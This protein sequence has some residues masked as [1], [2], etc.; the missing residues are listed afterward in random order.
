MRLKTILGLLVLTACVCLLFFFLMTPD[1]RLE[2]WQRRDDCTLCG[3]T[4]ASVKAKQAQAAS[5]TQVAKTERPKA[6]LANAVTGDVLAGFDAWSQRYLQATAGER[7][8]MIQEGQR[9]AHARRPIFKQLIQSDPRRALMEA[10]PMVVRQSLPAEIVSELEERVADR[11]ELRVYVAGPESK[12]NGDKAFLRYVET[13]TGRTY[14]TYVYG[15]REF[16]YRSK[17]E[18]HVIGV[19]MEGELALSESPLRRLEPG[20]I[21]PAGK[22]QVEVCPVSGKNTARAMP[23]PTPV[24][25]TVTAVETGDEVIFLCDGAH[26]RAYENGLIMGEAGT[27]G[28]QSFTGAMPSASVPSVG[29]VKV[30]Y[31]PAIFADQS[32]TPATE[33]VM[34]DGLRQAADFYQTQSY[35]RLTL[36]A[37]VT[38][39]VKLP[40]NQAW[41]NGKDTTSGFIKEVDGLGAEMAHAKEAARAAGY[42]WQDYH[43][44]CVRATGGARSPTSY[45]SIGIGQVWMRSDNA[46]TIAHEVG[47]AFG[48][49]H[50]NFWLTNGASV[51][52]PGGNEEYGDIYDNM[53]STSPPAGH[54]NTQAKNQI[55]WMPPEFAPPITASGLYRIH[56]FD[57]PRL[58][59]GKL[60]ALQVRKDAERTF[61][62]EYRTLFP[63]NTWV[64]N[65]L[66][67]G[68]KWSQN[69]GDNIQL[70]DTTP[71]SNNGKSDAPIAVGSTFSDIESGIHVT[72]VAVNPTTSPPS[73]DVQV[74][75]GSFPGNNVPTLTLS[76]S[77]PVVPTNTNVTFTA[78]AADLDGDTL[79]YSWR[80]HDG[81]ISPN[82]PTATR[83]FSSN[84]I[85]NVSCVVSDMKG[86][87]A[88]RNA[89][90]TVG[91]GGSRFTISGRVT[92]NGVGMVGVNVTTSG[93]NG[94]LTDSD[95]YYVIANLA[96][97]SY[98]ATPAGHGYVFNEEFN[99]SITVGPSFTGA[100]FT[101]EELPVVTLTAPTAVAVEGGA[102]GV[103]RLTR[104]GS[105]ALPLAVN[106]LVVRGTAAKTTDYTFAPDYT[107]IS[108]TPYFALT[109]PAD[110]STLDVVVAPVNDAS[111][112]GDEEVQLILGLD[113]AYV[114]GAQSSAAI[115]IQDNDTA[116][117][118]VSL[119]ASTAQ[120]VEGSGQPIT[121]T[122]RR[123]GSTG[124]DLI[125][126]YTIA[127]T[128]TAGNGVDYSTLSGTATI[129]Q[130]FASTTFSITPLD[131]SLAEATETV[132]LSIAS[133]ALFIADA[134][135]N[136]IS[137]RIVD[138]D[139][140]VV[141]LT[142]T[143]ATATEV[144]RTAPGA[145]PDPGTFLLTRSG[146]TSAALTVYYSVAGSALHGVDYEALPGSVTFP[147][148]ETQ[149][150]VTIMPRIEG[151][152]EGNELVILSI[153]DGNE[154]YRSGTSASGT[155]TISDQ[156]TDK[157]LLEVT[158][159]GGIAAEPS[160]NG[161]FR[162]TAKGGSGS[163]T[164]NYT[165]SGTATPGIDFTVLS[166]T[167]TLAL[168]GGTVT[169][170]ISVPVINDSDVEDMETVTLTLNDIPSS[171]YSL[172]D[173][174]KSAT[175]FI[176]DDEQP[177][178]FVDPQIGT[179]STHSISESTT[180]TTLKYYISRTG[181]TA[182][183]L[184]VN[185]TMTGT[186][187]SGVDFTSTNLT[188][189]ATIPIGAPGVDISFNTISDTTFEGTE[190]ATLSLS[191]GSYSRGP[192]AT[193][194]ITDDD[195]GAQTVNFASTGGSGSESNTT[196]SIPVSLSS[197]AVGT[198]TVD[199]LL[200]TGPRT[201]TMMAGTWV[202]VIRTGNSYSA[203]QSLD[204]V[205]FT[206]RG[207][208]QTI[209]GVPTT[210]YLAGIYVTSGS[211]GVLANIQM[212]SLSVTGLEVGGSAGA[213]ASSAIGTQNPAGGQTE[214]S[215]YYNIIAGGPDISQTST[216]D[217]GRIIY[218]PITSS[219]NC[220]V[221][222]RVLGMTGNSTAIKAGVTIRESTANNVRHM[223]CLAETSVGSHRA[224]YRLTSGGN[225]ASNQAQPTYTKPR[226]LRLQRS[227][228]DFTSSIS[229]D[230][231]AWTVVGPAQTLPLSTLCV[232]G[233]AASA[234]SDGLLT[235]ATFDNVTLSTGGALT[236][237]TIGYVNEPGSVTESGGTWTITASGSG[238]LHTTSST[239]DEGHMAGASVS[240]DFTL[241]ARLNN[242]SGGASNAQAGL[243]VRETSNYR[244]RALWYGMVA[245]A[246]AS[247][248]EYR[249]RLSAVSSGEGLSVDYALTPGTLTFA[250][251]EQT[252]NITLNVTND[253]LPEP[254]EFVT[255]MLRYPYRSLLGA[256]ST[257]TY[258]I[259]DDDVPTALLP[260]VGF[261]GAASSGLET[262]SP[263]QIAVTLSDPASTAV[264]IDYATNS[265]GTATGGGTDFTDISGTITFAPGETLK[266]ISLPVIDDSLVEA[267]ETVQLV[268]TAPTNAALS[269]T[270]T[271]TFTITDDDTP[272]VTLTATDAVANEA[273]DTGTFTFSRNGVTTSALTVN[274]TRSGTA[275]SG[276]DY[277]AIITPGTITFDIGEATKTVTV[278]PLQNTANEANETVILTL[279]AGSGYT[280]GSPSTATVTIEDDDV[281]TI[282]LTATD[283]IASEAP[284]NPGEF[285]LERTGPITSSVNVNISVSGTATNGTDYTS[286]ATTRTFGVG[287][288]SITIPVTVT[289][290]ST[291][292]GIEEVVISI[293][294]AA[295]YIVGTPSVANV[296]IIDDDLPPSVFISS[297]AS[298]STIINA[299]N[300]LQLQSTATD[301][302]L[303]SPLGYTWSQ[304]F[305]PG[306][307][308]FASPTASGSAASFSTPGIYGLRITVNDGQFTASDDLIVQ[309]G[310]FGYANWVGIDQGP[311]GV[312]GIS[313]E[314]AGGNYTLIGAG[315]GYTGTN[316]SGHMMFRQI[317]GGTGDATVTARL[318]SVS[319]P[320][321][322]LAGI[323][324]RDT[325]WKGAKRSNLVLTAGGSLQFRNRT[326][327]NVADTATTATGITFPCWMKLERVSGSV[328]ASYASDVAGTPGT[329]T[330]I[331]A[332]TAIT[333]GSNVV[334]MVV[335]AGGGNAT[336]TAQFDNVSVTPT[337]SGSALHSEDLGNYT[338]AGNSS[339]NAAVTTVNAIGGHDG[340]GSHFRY[341]QVWGDC[342]ITAR[343]TSHAG[344]IRG[345]QSGVAV[346]DTTDNGPFGFYGN[347]T[348]DGFQAHWRSSSGANPSTL[349]TGGSISNWIRLIRKGNS[350]AAYRA[351]NVSGVP[352]AWAQVTGNLPAPMTGPLLVGL[353]VDSNDSALTATGTFEGLSIEALNIAPVVD[354]GTIASLPPFNLN[355]TVTDDGRPTPPGATSVSWSFLSGPG[356]VSFANPA[357]EDTLATLS[358]NGTHTLRLTA[359]DGDSVVFG[360]LTFAGYLNPFAQWLDQNNVGN[361]NNLLVEAE[362]DADNDGLANLLEY[363]IGTNGTISSAN[364]QITT[365]A[366]VSADTYLRIS[367]P[368]NLAATDVTFTVEATS[369]LANPLS[370][371]SAGLVIEVNNSTTLQVRDNVPAGPG[372]QRFMRVKVTR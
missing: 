103:F 306:I 318:V 247:A 81:V 124:A 22:K 203:W 77:A 307:I 214:S 80:W 334:G 161:Q 212:D 266:L 265:S 333:M 60:Y 88:I 361:E 135:A 78:T 6:A 36:V 299:G 251:G 275:T 351:T 226:W 320:A 209:T 99:N 233:L 269:T 169:T 113:A 134:A 94:T 284:G 186:A 90:I 104:T 95:G 205:T 368:K 239:E 267:A 68:W 141:T 114:N 323:T 106:T 259:L 345:A 12:V 30:L 27:G 295:S 181:S 330:Q 249:A 367:I 97:G 201:A 33:A 353:L 289:Q 187:T 28:A 3:P 105:T 15:R 165:I 204:G 327:A 277:T 185:Y 145:V 189:T 272:V 123:S 256:P 115:T 278:A 20:E 46:S 271:H 158:A 49:L 207:T 174:S 71:G 136:A 160:T 147:A 62:G 338:L 198:E 297:P 329:W 221:T 13:R 155:V 328:T 159:I 52:G 76:P 42:D 325:S 242:I 122:L 117:P 298:K 154:A 354:T 314:A 292:E 121:C 96:A 362:A 38:P 63:A 235:Q 66:L 313:G 184:T 31:V 202:R 84:G 246:S 166:G 211:S 331:G 244:A 305:G 231:V 54:Y 296:T 50:A 17:P 43:C 200:E 237:R 93:T 188:G 366:P 98:S 14:E 157:P 344:A 111:S 240:G 156:S 319:G 87:I 112:E 53:G 229:A 163:L 293:S 192:N 358:M 357:V 340:S 9:L 206:Q 262:A 144:D 224:V 21:P 270:S 55:R 1:R 85:Y 359:D 34:M 172:W 26:I 288:S 332:P 369:D 120:T 285:T 213:F 311:P 248:P 337:V 171:N 286:I 102:S 25:E 176:R 243:M 116:L 29:V 48:L 343:L 315:T 349:Q 310:G 44:F 281:N 261:T 41:Y 258:A 370:W 148:G 303:P 223:T 250:A 309:A 138:D 208:T 131:D 219:A 24:A 58:E 92:K 238:I 228:N 70:L 89:V 177:T 225:A 126:A 86:G 218:V 232:V 167:A 372:V 283:S 73:L 335:S 363:A 130:N 301:D 11:G 350:V 282:T 190:T 364:P 339:V 276:S 257:Y 179:G 252:K 37:T 175:L 308:T 69:N 300:G 182:A 302:G 101:V 110:S 178:V 107:A 216:S 274:F 355:A 162:I 341:Q 199:Y 67:L 83:S 152:G 180:T 35:G 210:G 39:P 279:T 173:V 45:G 191:S 139:S 255:V 346:R 326:T 365:L 195:A 317:L 109:I 268:L 32:Q 290:D 56:A 125:V 4:K 287:I 253:L 217:N 127:T 146:D 312:R 19:A 215:G 129:P 132:R 57:Q 65:G 260:S 324:L 241:T 264:T 360:D 194:Y 347:T 74:N 230:G 371:S 193:I 342:I 10:V 108:N 8:D 16:D 61:W 18:V 291:T 234:R 168:N 149:R 273:G 82:A 170:N 197:P 245:G 2:T 220:T 322:R 254:V 133:G 23:P 137:T 164:V 64:S 263:A 40:R 196:V 51:A 321:N 72:T 153:A 128:S 79:A 151:Y 91:N 119:T 5:L 294:A 59:S 222:A 336:A 183:A 47:H 100:N 316:D 75:L 143:D 140:Q 150:T 142:T 236:G 356:G 7:A 348:I 280:F 118:R 304:L 352:G 227:G